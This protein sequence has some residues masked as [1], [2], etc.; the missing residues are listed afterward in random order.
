MFS[1]AFCFSF[2][3]Y[4]KKEV[5]LVVKETHL[6]EVEEIHLRVRGQLR[7][8]VCTKC[9]PKKTSYETN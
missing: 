1:L 8:S 2:F 4:G 6:E 5:V 9:K 3:P 7:N